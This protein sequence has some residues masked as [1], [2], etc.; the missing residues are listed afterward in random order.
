[1]V[2]N[3]VGTLVDVGFRNINPSYLKTIIL[4]KDRKYCS[5]MAPAKGLFLW[6]SSYPKK[7]RIKHNKES[8]LM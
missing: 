5:K 1:M 4:N 3:I 6:N 2:R 7:Y 8:I